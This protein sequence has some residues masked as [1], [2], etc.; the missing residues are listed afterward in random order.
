M[1]D[2]KIDLMDLKVGF[3]GG[4]NMARAIGAGLIKKGI[5]EKKTF[6]SVDFSQKNVK[7]IV[8]KNIDFFFTFNS[9]GVLNPDK[10]WVSSRTSQTLEFWKELGTRTSLKNQDVIDKCDVIF[11]AVKPQMLKDL[12]P[13]FQKSLNSP[14]CSRKLF[15]SILVGVTLK[16]LED[17]NN[18]ISIFIT[19]HQILELSFLMR[20]KILW[21]RGSVNTLR[22]R[23]SESS[24][25]CQTHL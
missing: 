11:I 9:T 20:E 18:R 12:S 15:V 5:S 7:N 14:S 8:E 19:K 17:V 25:P 16:T 21:F 24:E 4:G 10:V 13:D 6:C 2:S 3:I 1:E 22:I 23:G